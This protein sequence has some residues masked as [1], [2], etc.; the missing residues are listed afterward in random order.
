MKWRVS[1]ITTTFI[2]FTSQVVYSFFLLWCRPTSHTHRQTHMWMWWKSSQEEEK[3]GIE[4]EIKIW[5]V[6]R[7]NKINDVLLQVPAIHSL[8]FPI[9][10]TV[11]LSLACTHLYT[12]KKVKYLRFLLLKPF[13]KVEHFSF[14]LLIIFHR[15]AMSWWDRGRERELTHK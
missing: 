6:L 14:F 15:L 2:H 9:T 8:F 4:H 12:S 3:R 13:F 5:L 10:F 1:S 11:P 7:E